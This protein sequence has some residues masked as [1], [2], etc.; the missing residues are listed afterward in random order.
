MEFHLDEAIE[1]LRRTPAV[2]NSLLLE[3]PDVWSRKNEGPDTWCAFDILGHLIQGEETDWIPRARIILMEGEARPFDPFDR[4]AQF[5]KSIGKSLTELLKA[6]EISRENNLTTITQ[7]NLTE[8]QLERRGVHPELGTVTLRQ[9][10]ATWVVHDLS[11]LAQISRVMCKQYGDA[12]GPWKAY[13]P[14]LS[15]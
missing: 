14:V 12:V 3:L 8:E 6:F 5:Q 10:L 1:I 11:H 4:Y 13:L 9:L 15:R 7:W 2:L